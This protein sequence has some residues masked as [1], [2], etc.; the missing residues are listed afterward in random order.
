MILVSIDTLRA[1]HLSSYG[2][3][4]ETSPFLDA[5]AEKGVRFTDARS[6]SPWTLPTHT[7]MMTGLHPHRHGVVDDTVQRSQKTKM[8]AEMMK[9]NGFKTAGVVSSLYVSSVFGFDKG[10]DH[11]EDFSLHTERANLSGRVDAKGVVDA[12][13]SWWKRQEEGKPIFLFI[14]FYDAHYA[15]EPP[16]PYDTLFDRASKEGDLRYRNYF[17]FQKNPPSKEEFLHLIA[18]YDESIRYVDDQLNR[19]SKELEGRDLRWV[20]TSDHGEEFGERGSWGHAHTLFQEQLHVP[21]VISG[22]GIPSKV[23]P[24]R[25]GIQDIV[26]TIASWTKEGLAV[27]VDGI[28]LLNGE[29]PDRVFVAETSRFHSCRLSIAKDGYRLEWDLKNQSISL[30]LDSDPFEKNDRSKA[31]PDRVETMKQEL[32]NIVGFRWQTPLDG[33]LN[34]SYIWDG[35]KLNHGKKEVTSG[36]RFTILPFDRS[37]D[38]HSKRYSSRFSNALRPDK[39]SPLVYL[40]S[41]FVGIQT[42]P[43]NVELLLQ[44]LGYMQED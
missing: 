7:T 17:H 10:F 11:F 33:S 32:L 14:H 13:L 8:L 12:A 30:F 25:V 22:S 37:F 1:D 9:K 41:D 16:P 26:P 24:S 29:I 31:E 43:P 27:P 3:D 36:D 15:Y 28:D 5:L 2:Y 44:E 19:L 35:S 23:I 6:P 18:Q 4:R 40:G 34:A 38:F 21:L 20:V 42:L 39:D